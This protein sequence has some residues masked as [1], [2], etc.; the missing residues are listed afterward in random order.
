MLNKLLFGVISYNEFTEWYNTPLNHL[1]KK[2]DNF[3]SY[4]ITFPML[5]LDHDV[6]SH[7]LSWYFLL[8][9]ALFRE[10]I[11]KF[12]QRI[13]MCKSGRYYRILNYKEHY[14]P[15]SS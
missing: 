4:L 5:G 13:H 10:L 7:W 2:I 12:E 15:F 6:M 1:K 14:F 8:L 11:M 3:N 9:I